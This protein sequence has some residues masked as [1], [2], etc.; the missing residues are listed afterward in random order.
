LPQPREAGHATG[1]GSARRAPR[2]R[3]IR[4]R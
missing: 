1:T 2:R 3:R 4:D